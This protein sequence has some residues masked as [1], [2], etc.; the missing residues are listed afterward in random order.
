MSDILG[1]PETFTF[2]GIIVFIMLSISTHFLDRYSKILPYLCQLAA[3]G[4][5]GQMYF[6]NFLL[7]ASM[8]VR[9][10]TSAIYFILAIA[11]AIRLSVLVLRDTR[12]RG[13]IF[14]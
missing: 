1:I 10:F 7:E 4:G 12:H 2:M 3:L 8:Q 11:Y 14:A 5:L 9:D 6:T 13:G